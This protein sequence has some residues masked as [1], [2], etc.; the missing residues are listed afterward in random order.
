MHYPYFQE[1]LHFQEINGRQEDYHIFFTVVPALSQLL[2]RLKAATRGVIWKEFFLEIFQNS[3]ENTWVRVSLLIKLQVSDLQLYLKRDS[4]QVFFGKSC[5]VF[6]ST[7]FIEQFRETASVRQLQSFTKYLELT[8]VFTWNSALREK[9]NF[10][11]S[12]VFC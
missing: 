12:R 8:L 2:I 5:E 9:L 7:Y 4:V 1:Q 11:F 6:N 10:Y 3:Q